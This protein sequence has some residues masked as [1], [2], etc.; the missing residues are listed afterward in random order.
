MQLGDPERGR[1]RDR[2]D[3][4]AQP[5]LQ[6][7]RL[8]QCRRAGLRGGWQQWWPDGTGQC[9]DRGCA[10]VGARGRV[11]GDGVGGAP[12]RLRFTA[13]DGLRGRSGQH[14]DGQLPGDRGRSGVRGR[15]VPVDAGAH[16]QLVE[17]DGRRLRARLVVVDRVRGGAGRRRCAV[18][19][20]RRARDPL[21]SPGRRLGSSRLGRPVAGPYSRGPRGHGP[22]RADMAVLA[23]GSSGR[24]E[25]GGDG[26]VGVRP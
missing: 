6:R 14:G 20:A 1:L 12:Q 26:R 13:H 23:I 4:L 8:G 18:H 21:R 17:R 15:S 9:F 7:G 25:A 10:E 22:D 2:G 24:D 19:P 5:E 11:A 3:E 16:L